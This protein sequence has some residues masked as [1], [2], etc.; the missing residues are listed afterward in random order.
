MS[1]QHSIRIVNPHDRFAFRLWLIRTATQT[2]EKAENDGQKCDDH[3]VAPA[4]NDP[5]AA[6]A[7]NRA[8]VPEHAA[9]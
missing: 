8:L 6:N 2:H 4:I 7:A 1:E 9:R 3:E 5:A